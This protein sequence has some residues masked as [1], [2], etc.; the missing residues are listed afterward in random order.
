MGTKPATGEISLN[1]GGFWRSTVACSSSKYTYVYIYISR[2]W[3]YTGCPR[4]NVP[5]FG[6]VFLMIKYTDI[7][8]NTDV[9]S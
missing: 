5:G 4:K 1:T 8:Q 9:Q 7:T 2:I 6:W 3:V